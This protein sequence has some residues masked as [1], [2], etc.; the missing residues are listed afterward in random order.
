MK[1][2]IAELADW[3]RAR[4]D[5]AVLPHVSPD[6]DALGAT[7]ALTLGLHKLHKRA[8]V[9]SADRVPAMYHFLPGLDWVRR[10]GALGFDP[11]CLL[12]VDVA[13]FDRAGDRGQLTG[14]VGDWAQIDHHET[15]DGFASV[16]M[17][18]SEAPA[19]G[20]LALR[21]LDELGVPIDRDMATLLYAAIS[22]DTGNFA[23]S[24]TTG[25]ALRATARL[26]ETGFDIADAN[27]RLFRM[28]TVARTRLLGKALAGF[29]LYSGGRV[30]LTRLP[31]AMIDECGAEY[32]DSEGIINFLIEME[33]VE[34]ALTAEARDGGGS[35][36]F[37]LRSLGA[38]DVSAIAETFG[39]GG[40]VNAAGM[41]ID[42]PLDEAAELALAA[43]RRALP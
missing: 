35:T 43:V 18:D 34:V 20:V 33:G 1:A 22:T 23:Y 26:L 16:S 24:N 42:G 29:E 3:I 37:S 5:I 32:P 9:A 14:R 30:A 13:S 12:F 17:I 41:S 8:A 21:L 27:L 19:S 7:L 6:G 25:E 36:K 38:V 39:G 28:R 11:Q 10:P 15:N 2:T 31:Q 40:H 4:D